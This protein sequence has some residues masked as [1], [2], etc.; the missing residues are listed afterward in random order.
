MA[1]LTLVL[2]RCR[3]L[4]SHGCSHK[5][6]VLPAES[7]I[8]QRD[9]FS[10]RKK[11]SLEALTPS[12]LGRDAVSQ[13]ERCA[14]CRLSSKRAD[15]AAPEQRAGLPHQSYGR[16]PRGRSQTGSHIP[17]TRTQEF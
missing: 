16:W 8:D 2:R 6:A 15:A 5:H 12:P 13:V 17:G 1:R 10:R 4:G 7:L 14:V 3:G 11:R 9:A